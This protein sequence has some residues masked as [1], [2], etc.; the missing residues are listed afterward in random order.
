MDIAQK[1]GFNMGLYYICLIYSPIMVD[2]LIY[3]GN[4]HV[5]GM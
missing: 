3:M 5:R 1:H 4:A 2:L